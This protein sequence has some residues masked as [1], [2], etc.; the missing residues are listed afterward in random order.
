MGVV[1]LAPLFIIAITEL[2]IKVPATFFATVGMGFAVW[3]INKFERRRT[4]N[5]KDA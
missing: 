5:A 3:L 2:F 1:M 4:R